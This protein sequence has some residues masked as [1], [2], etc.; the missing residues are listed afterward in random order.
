MKINQAHRGFL[1]LE[2]LL[3]LQAV[4]FNFSLSF[5]FGLFQSPVLSCFQRKELHQQVVKREVKGSR[6]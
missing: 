3:P 4:L 2:L 5:F 6:D 1:C